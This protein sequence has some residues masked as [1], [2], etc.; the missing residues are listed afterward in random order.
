MRYTVLYDPL[1]EKRL[2]DLWSDHP[3]RGGFS[4]A[5]NEMDG[6]L[7]RTPL[8]AGFP[9]GEAEPPATA[10]LDLALRITR[11]PENLR[12]YAIGRVRVVYSVHD[13]DRTVVVWTAYL[14]NF[15]EV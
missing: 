8:S 3:D 9:Y 4:E 2:V 7:T 12:A 11:L 5:L 1:V 10:E 13:N 15:D 14:A 6:R